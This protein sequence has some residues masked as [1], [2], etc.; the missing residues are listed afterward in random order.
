MQDEPLE[1]KKTLALTLATDRQRRAPVPNVK[2]S[3]FLRGPE[4][5]AGVKPPFELYYDSTIRPVKSL[6]YFLLSQFQIGNRFPYF[7]RHSA[8]S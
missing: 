8:D 3:D 1:K 6:L 2:N 7:A 4:Q 5:L